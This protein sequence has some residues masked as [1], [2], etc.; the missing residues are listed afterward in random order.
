M[1]GGY[2]CPPFANPSITP[3]EKHTMT[4]PEN[5]IT[6]GLDAEAFIEQY[7]ERQP[8][9]IR[10]AVEHHGWTW[11]QVNELLQRCDPTSEDFKLS[12]NGLR[13]KP[14]YV[15]QYRD[16]GTLR[17]RLIKPV[18]YDYLRQ[19]ATLIANK[20][21]HEPLVDVFARQVAEFTGRQV[22]S[23]AY[24][25]FGS[26]DSY[27]AHW[28]T[29]DVF[30]LQLIGRKRWILHQPSFDAPLYTQQSRDLEAHYPR[31]KEAWLDV[32][33]EPGDLL[34][35]PRGWWHN[36]LPLGEGTFHLALGTFPAYAVDYV[37]WALQ[38]LP[39]LAAARQSLRGW[40]QD[41]ALMAQVAE[42]LT[43]RLLDEHSY[44]RF[45]DEF[46]GAVRVESPLAIETFG[47][48]TGPALPPDSRLRLS[49]NLAH[50]LEQ[51]YLIA[52]GIRLNLDATGQQLIQVVAMHPGIRLDQL[53]GRCPM[54]DP[55]QLQALVPGLCHQDI[56]HL[57]DAC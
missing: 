11:R 52:N 23:S 57:T 27:K 40:D 29:R 21:V 51:G 15:E 10:N 9:L 46:Q 1:L 24:A 35:V 25:A 2:P 45:L 20:L 22:V 8:L 32:V 55:A 26:R 37:S 41:R 50:G 53:A 39:E 7:Q 6:F 18:I 3:T 36:P 43:S 31:P 56:L 34:Y 48:P 49:G 12:C 44:Q 13:P 4:Q 42:H 5:K 47:T 33:L 16:I 19:G 30:A 38:Q 17:H 14:E 54:V 28:D